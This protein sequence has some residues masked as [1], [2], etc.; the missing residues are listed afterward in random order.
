[1]IGI[2]KSTLQNVDKDFFAVNSLNQLLKTS[3]NACLFCDHID[4][5]FKLQAYTNVL[6]RVNMFRFN[7]ILITDNLG[8]CQDLVNASYAKKRFLYLY[9][10]EWLYINN[11]EYAHIKKILLN[12][13][14]ELIART[15]SHAELIESLFKKPKY[16][17]PEWDYKTLVEIDNNE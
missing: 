12:D 17:M 2:L 3:T 9:H 7:G 13:N 6:Q 4:N 5:N 16:V 1:M 14:I 11:L 10:L 8:R 15:K